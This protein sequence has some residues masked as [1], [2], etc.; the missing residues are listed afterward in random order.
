MGPLLYLLSD[1]ALPSYQGDR[2]QHSH[3]YMEFF[4]IKG[5]VQDSNPRYHCQDPPTRPLEPL[6]PSQIGDKGAQGLGS[7]LANSTNLSNLTLILDGNQIGDE[8]ASGL[9]STLAN[10]NN[11]LNLTLYLSDS[12]INAIGASD[13]GSAL[14]NCTNL[15][16]LKLHLCENQVNESQQQL[17]VKSKCIKS[18]RLVVFEI[19]FQ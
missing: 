18:K 5:A 9:G 13:L 2:W 14:T 11:I 6:S 1:L 16:N 19:K 10:C 7:A 3:F 17:K 12:Q 8:G 15:S 4:E